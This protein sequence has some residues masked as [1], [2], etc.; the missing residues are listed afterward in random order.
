MRDP[1]TGGDHEPQQREDAA[2]SE[3]IL[4]TARDG[5]HGTCARPCLGKIP[6]ILPTRQTIDRRTVHADPKLPR[7]AFLHVLRTCRNRDGSLSPYATALPVETASFIRPATQPHLHRRERRRKS[8]SHDDRRS[9]PVAPDR[10]ASEKP[11][12]YPLTI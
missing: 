5:R 2:V 9:G 8:A 3:R 7:M 10:P 12:K 4:C 6:R 1:I 11:A